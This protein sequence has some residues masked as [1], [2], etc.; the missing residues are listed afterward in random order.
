MDQYPVVIIAKKGSWTSSIKVKNLFQKAVKVGLSAISANPFATGG[1]TAAKESLS[2]FNIDA[3]IEQRA[4]YLIAN[5]LFDTIIHLI[6]EEA[7]KN[8]KS[9]V[10]QTT[11][12]E[13]TIH[14][15]MNGT[16]VTIPPTFFS[17]PTELPIVAN[18]SEIYEQWLIEVLGV[19]EKNARKIKKQFKK[20]FFIA[21]V[22]EWHSQK[23]YYTPILNA[24][25]CP[26]AKVWEKEYQQQQYYK[27]IK[28]FYH[29]GALGDKKLPLSKM[30]IKPSFAV[31]KRC[32]SSSSDEYSFSRDDFM[33]NHN[34]NGNIHDYIAQR[35]IHDQQ[36]LGLAVEQERLIFLLGQPG[37]GKSSFCYHTIHQLLSDED[38]DQNLY[39]V[40]LKYIENINELINQPL[41]EI[42]KY[43]KNIKKIAFKEENS[44]L[45]L[46]GL[47]ELY[48]SNGISKNQLKDFYHQLEQA[49]KN[50]PSLSIIITARYN[51][52]QINSI[53]KKL[54]TVLKLGVTT[55][56][57][58][59]TW[60]QKYNEAYPQSKLTIA[61]LNQIHKASNLRHVKELIEQPI[62]LHLVAKSE[63][64]IKDGLNRTAI[65]EQLFD[66]LL[67]RSWAQDDGPL[68]KFQNLVDYKETY[69][70]WLR[71]IAYTIYTSDF[72]YINRK[73]L[74]QLETTKEV[75]NHINT[76][77]EEQEA[78]K[79]LLVAF[80]FQNTKKHQADEVE[81]RSN[82]A[83]EFLH[84]S[85]Q[86]YLAA[87]YIWEALLDKKKKRYKLNETE[88]L[89]LFS[90]LFSAKHLSPSMLSLLREI[91]ETDDDTQKK[92]ELA[93]RI[94]ELLP[95]FLDNQFL[96]SYNTDEKILPTDKA[97][98]TA[99]GCWFILNVLD[100]TKQIIPTNTN[101]RKYQFILT[102]FLKTH[103][104]SL[105]KLNLS[106]SN[107]NGINLNRINLSHSYLNNVSLKY[108]T[109]I[110]TNLS[111]TDLN[112]ANLSNT[113][114][115]GVD[116]S[117]ANL[118]NSALCGT[119]LTSACLHSSDLRN[120][121]F[122][123]ATFHDTDLRNAD[124]NN[125]DLRNI[126]LKKIYLQDTSFANTKVS[127]NFYSQLEQEDQKVFNERF[128]INYTTPIKKDWDKHYLIKEK[129]S[130]K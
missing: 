69:I 77:E 85:L 105:Y 59:Q 119:N 127:H 124:L 67:E 40:K 13:N 48:M 104:N 123:M 107:L 21:V 33:E 99:N 10:N 60:L 43:L 74:S 106:Y 4:H 11:F 111:S 91:I 125:A 35:V 22:N 20:Q 1:V 31:H 110:E 18:T 17:A 117:D 81:E 14:E 70:D 66:N 84:K 100:C 9:L 98:H 63:V 37:Q 120:T 78:L 83:I 94:E 113:K 30:Y 101:V 93:N 76:K 80:Y 8:Y 126:N 109:L 6:P 103:S 26:F 89:K 25:E 71:E 34:F 75:K 47:D 46:D 23:E 62:L 54:S 41:Q 129:P 53:N 19:A 68:K 38:F 61:M 50:H 82:N 65:Y 72:E 90:D 87:E 108:A 3:P 32:F 114:L 27:R 122:R 28:E 24:L 96:Y 128:Y 44:V 51:Y 130:K 16:P 88:A 57:Q 12:L 5:A 92:E 29:Q 52:L 58:Q 15:E 115:M 2:L 95:Y 55:L 112:N 73:T 79:D 102:N 45:I 7:R 36:P 116:L 97:Q 42:E 64:E 86:E 118:R 56:Q 49:I 39:F 121:D